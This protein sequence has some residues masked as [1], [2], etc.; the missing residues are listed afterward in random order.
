MSHFANFLR[1][2]LNIPA[3]T[4]DILTSPENLLATF[5]SKIINIKLLL[6]MEI[7]TTNFFVLTL[8]G[9]WK[10]RGWSGIKAILYHCYSAIVIFANIS[11]LISGIM[12]LE[13]TNIDI[14]AFIDNVSLLLSLVTIRQ[15]TACAIGNRGDIKEIIDSLGRSPFKPQ[16]KEEENIVKRF[17]D[18]TG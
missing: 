13:F 3:N 17:D 5:Y 2:N 9:L 4:L 12:D 1:G 15:K 14:A 11:F 6:T 18:L 8:V 10:P 16:D 7:L